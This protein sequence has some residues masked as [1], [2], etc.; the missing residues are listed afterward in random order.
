M[1]AE[2]LFQRSA[3]ARGE[4]C[5]GGAVL[6]VCSA[7]L[8]RVAEF[9]DQ[10]DGAM[11]FAWGCLTGLL[12]RADTLAASS[13]SVVAAGAGRGAA[14]PH[15]GR[16][17]ASAREPWCYRWARL[18]LAILRPRGDQLQKKRCYHPSR[19]G[20]TSRAEGQAGNG[21]RAR[22]IRPV[23]SSSTRPGPRRTWSA[24]MAGDHGDTGCAATHRTVIGERSP[25]SRP[26]G[27]TGSM[28]LAFSTDPSTGAA[29][30]LTSNSSSCPR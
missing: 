4:G 2:S 9:C 18:D 10:M 27:T 25:S 21:I 14:G 16:D 17:P 3:R 15:F 23:L 26:C 1:D 11:A 20:P 19:T 5:R 6:P 7:S 12:A 24:P 8:W 28:R 22:L 29:S 30:G 13:A